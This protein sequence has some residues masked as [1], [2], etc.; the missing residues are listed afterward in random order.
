L[1]RSYKYFY[2][3]RGD[4]VGNDVDRTEKETCDVAAR[5]DRHVKPRANHG[6]KIGGMMG[7]TGR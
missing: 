7:S 5:R 3:Q 2:E 1:G 4:D 6:C